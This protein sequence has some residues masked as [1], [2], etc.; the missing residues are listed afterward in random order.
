MIVTDFYPLTTAGIWYINIYNNLY[1]R[2]FLIAPYVTL[3]TEKTD[4]DDDD[5][6]DDEEE[7]D[8]DHDDDDDDDGIS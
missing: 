4:G 7:E 3:A 5:D 6:D 8:E 1:F 2:S